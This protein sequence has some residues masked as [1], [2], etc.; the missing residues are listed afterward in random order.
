MR[1]IRRVG[2]V[3]L[4]LL[5]LA[6]AAAEAAF[7]NAGPPASCAGQDASALATSLG[8]GFA[9]LVTHRGERV[10]RRHRFLHVTPLRRQADR[11]VG[12]PS[13]GG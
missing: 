7:A 8:R 2:A 11:S 3:L 6:L 1:R 10:E 13:W 9:G 12:F 4:S 5:V